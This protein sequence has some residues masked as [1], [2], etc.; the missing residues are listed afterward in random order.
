MHYPVG[1]EAV[2]RDIPANLKDVLIVKIERYTHITFILSGG[3]I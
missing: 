3:M 1:S 2:R